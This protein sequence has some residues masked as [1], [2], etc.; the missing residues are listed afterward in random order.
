MTQDTLNTK[1]ILIV[2]DDPRIR[3]LL[4]RYLQQQGFDADAYADASRLDQR[5]QQRRPDLIVLDLMLPGED[6]LSVVRR[7]RATGETIPI[8]L[9]TAK[10][11]DID[12]IVGL[13]MG[14]DDYL[15]KPFNPRELVARIQ[16][17]LR[18]QAPVPALAAETAA[19][20]SYPFGDFVLDAGCRELRRKGEPVA[21]TPAEFAM[22]LVLVTHPRK[23]LSR[24]RLMQLARGR[25][26]EAFD[27]SVDVQISRL[28]KL[29]EAD[30]SEPRFIRT[31]WGFGYVF[32]PDGENV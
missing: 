19:G 5:L 26:I 16:A 2:D 31:V 14:A 21:L 22:L 3:E 27:R 29:I 11:D 30:S 1:K 32:V 12:R 20:E 4:L 8:I 17:V 13:E 23:P 15:G 6:G 10:G 9:L 24:E 25:D 28:R 7:L 18:R